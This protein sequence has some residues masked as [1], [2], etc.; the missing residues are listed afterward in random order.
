MRQPHPRPWHKGSVFGEGPRRRL[1][2]EQ[3]ARFKF[4]LHA[5]RGVGRITATAQDVGHALLK[6]LSRKDGRCDPSHATLAERAKCHERTV[7]RALE[8]MAEIGLLRWQ[9]RIV[10]AGWR[11][12]QTSNAYELTPEAAARPCD[13]QNVRETKTLI[14]Q[15][16]FTLLS[17]DE[18]ALL[19][20]N[21]QLAV[22]AQGTL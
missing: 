21:R 6:H 18:Q 13:G 11:A 10:R 9:R 20:R 7:R 17:D 1:D 2:R 22:L 19:N 15:S 14:N 5:H 12:E 4:L 16:L 3:R 8:R